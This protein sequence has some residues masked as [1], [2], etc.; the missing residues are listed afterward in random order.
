MN[1]SLHKNLLSALLLAFALLLSSCIKDEEAN[2]ECDILSAWVE[3]EDYATNFYHVAQ[4]RHE[5]ISSSEKEIIF[6]VR[7]L[8]A[9][10]TK[11]PIQF[12][13]TP[14]AT[15]VPD[16]GSVQDFTAGP[17]IYTVTS[18]DGA[19]KREYKVEFR[20]ASLPSF[21][22]SFEN[23]EV[24]EGSNRNQYHKFYELDQ[25]GNHRNIWVSGNEGVA[26]TKYASTP[27]EYPTRSINDGYRGLGVCLST[28]D[29]GSLG[30][31]MNKPIAAGNLFLGKFILDNVLFNPLKT[32]EF[33]I[34]IDKEPI[35]V[36][37]YYKYQ[38]GKEF[39]NAKMEVDKN[40]IDEASIYAVFYRNM[41]EEGKDVKLYG[42]DV[43]TNPNILKIAQVKTL[44]ATDEW[45]HFEMFF[46]GKDADPQILASQG[47]NMT[48]VFSSSKEGA[49][50]E[51]A[52]GSILHI[53]EVEVFFDNE[54]E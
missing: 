6:T 15:I 25:S 41:D 37:G 53:D 45:T 23:V 29:A 22:F 34:P 28:Q 30:R 39:T 46:E 2:K 33:G 5:N 9:L 44:P 14:G 35:R 19:W 48:L 40:R 26:L 7:S 27:D 21:K 10:P 3:G 52:I 24:V 50:F 47:Y 31:M 13:L 12:T 54:E 20:E 18:A 36:T 38:P 42:D 16:N 11:I 51:G 4:M 32:T 1:K 49:N 43:F 17:V 8:Y